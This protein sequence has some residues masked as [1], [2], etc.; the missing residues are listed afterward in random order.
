MTV[1]PLHPSL[2][3]GRWRTLSLLE[4]LG[5]V[6][7]EVGRAARWMPRDPAIG[8]RALDRAFELLDL[9]V[10]DPRWRTR[11]HELTRAREVLR[12]ASLGGPT[13]GSDLAAMERWFR[14][15]AVA[16]RLRR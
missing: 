13:Y 16:A 3:A 2:A 4:Q 7:S 15:F 5:N 8:G 11:L 6:G 10:T 14:P 9:T 1:P 12:D